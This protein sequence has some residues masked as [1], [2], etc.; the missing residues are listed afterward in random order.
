MRE[1]RAHSHGCPEHVVTIK[2]NQTISQIIVERVHSLLTS[3]SVRRRRRRR[4]SSS[5]SGS[6]S[7]SKTLRNLKEWNSYV[8]DRPRMHVTGLT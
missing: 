2:P 6:S 4:R 1:Y 3:L 5:S 8:S 7:S